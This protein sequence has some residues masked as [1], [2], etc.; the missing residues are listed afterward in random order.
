MISRERIDS[1][2][3]LPVHD[4]ERL[5]T[6]FTWDVADIAAEP[7]VICEDQTRDVMGLSIW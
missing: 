4:R 7:R 1:D 3:P 5:A 6:G 2:N